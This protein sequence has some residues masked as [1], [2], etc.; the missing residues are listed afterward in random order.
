MHI[1]KRMN[2]NNVN[3]NSLI[4]V[5]KIYHPPWYTIKELTNL[6]ILPGEI[7][8]ARGVCSCSSKHSVRCSFF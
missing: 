2:T 6:T 7:A 8:S 1:F 4:F 3:V 5:R